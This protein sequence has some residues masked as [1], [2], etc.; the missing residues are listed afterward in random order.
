V[1]GTCTYNLAAGGVTESVTATYYSDGMVTA[2]DAQAACEA[3]KGATWT[4]R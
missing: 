2:A 1:L 3:I 4:P